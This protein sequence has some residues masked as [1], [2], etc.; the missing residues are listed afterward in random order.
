[1]PS[2]PSTTIDRPT[3]QHAP[4]HD[5]IAQVI[6]WTIPNPGA[7]NGN[8]IG[9]HMLAEVLAELAHFGVATP[10]GVA[11]VL[12]V[13]DNVHRPP[14]LGEYIAAQRVDQLDPA[15][16]AKAT[17]EHLAALGAVDG[18]LAHEV[19]G[20]L[21]QRAVEQLGESL[22]G[23]VEQ[24]RKKHWTPPAKAVTEAVA[25]GLRAGTPAEQAIESDDLVQAWRTVTP[26]VPQ[27][28][29]I[30]RLYYRALL[31]CGYPL[32]VDEQAPQGRN[33]WLDAAA[34]GTPELVTPSARPHVGSGDLAGC[35]AG[36]KSAVAKQWDSAAAVLNARAAR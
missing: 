6:G 9:Q 1:M 10:A 11:R 12:E 33:A 28:D 2:S 30:A 27:L 19:S 4:V 14:A 17:Q 8:R 20:H 5:V 13:R 15:A 31:L 34:G 24:L 25:G 35:R 16:I 29:R 36:R 3:V 26:A 23:I 22:D 32:R 18:P 7:P 21:L